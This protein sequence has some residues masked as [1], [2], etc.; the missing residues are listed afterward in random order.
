LVDA[1][2]F[3]VIPAAIGESGRGLG[4]DW[5]NPEVIGLNRRCDM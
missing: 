5:Y 3:A 2:I 4:R 1:V